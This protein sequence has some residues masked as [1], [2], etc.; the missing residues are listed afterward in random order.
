MEVQHL[1]MDM[2]EYQVSKG[3]GR[4]SYEAIA[5]SFQMQPSVLCSVKLELGLCKPHQ[6]CQLAF[7]TRGTGE[8]LEGR[9][10]D[11]PSSFAFSSF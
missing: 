8:T 9:S 2:Y 7:I 4:A 11:F 10:G 6:L 3:L 5:F 1:W